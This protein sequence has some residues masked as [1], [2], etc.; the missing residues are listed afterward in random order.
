[1]LDECLAL[2]ERLDQETADR[3]ACHGDL[4]ELVDARCLT[5]HQE[6]S[7]DLTEK[8]EAIE[9]A[10]QDLVERGDALF[11]G[12]EEWGRKLPERLELESLRLRSDLRKLQQQ[13]DSV[14]FEISNFWMFVE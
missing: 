9:R 14:Q 7:A 3:V 5:L 6:L 4:L 11:A 8:V 2:Q 10:A 12:I 13:C 1:M